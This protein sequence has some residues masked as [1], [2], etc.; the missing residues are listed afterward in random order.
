MLSKVFFWLEVYLVNQSGEKWKKLSPM[1]Y[2][3]D[4]NS[5]EQ[6]DA[7]ASGYLDNFPPICG[8][9][10]CLPVLPGR[11]KVPEVPPMPAETRARLLKTAS[12]WMGEKNID[13][14]WYFTRAQREFGI[15][16]S[17]GEIGVY[18]VCIGAKMN[19]V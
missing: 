13:T 8:A 19:V 12:G 15:Y 16:G 2:K 5:R 14:V 1:S 3:D 7:C 18:H 6:Q 4:S 9:D 10:G 17:V 11:D